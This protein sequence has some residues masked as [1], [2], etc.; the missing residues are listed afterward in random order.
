[1]SVAKITDTD[2]EVTF[3]KI[4]AIVKN[5]NGNVKMVADRMGGLYYIKEIN[6]E[7]TC[8]A[9]NDLRKTQE[10]IWHERIGHLNQHDLFQMKK[11]E[12]T[13]GMTWT[14]ESFIPPCEIFLQANYI[15]NRCPTKTLDGRTAFDKW[16]ENLPDLRHLRIFGE[17]AV[18]IDKNISRGKLDPPE[19]EIEPDLTE[20]QEPEQQIPYM[21]EN[22]HFLEEERPIFPEDLLEEE[23][24]EERQ[25]R[26]EEEGLLE[27]EGNLRSGPGRPKI[28]RTGNKGRPTKQYSMIQPQEEIPNIGDEMESEQENCVLMNIFE[29]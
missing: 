4:I 16:T 18:V 10:M 7:G 17:K 29:D 8:M 2:H 11:N 12:V 6:K 13:T 23:H 28:L 27:A 19:I 21:E 24:I 9:S 3:K 15:R 1:M 25:N 22:E 5:E 26:L 20:N 14:N